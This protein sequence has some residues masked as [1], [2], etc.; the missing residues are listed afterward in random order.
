M[1]RLWARWPAFG[2]SRRLPKPLP[3]SLDDREHIVCEAGGLGGLPMRAAGEHGL[4]WANVA[5]L[6]RRDGLMVRRIEMGDDL[7][8]V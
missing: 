1:R 6:L 2:P 7:G 4:D 8:A 5:E 3:R